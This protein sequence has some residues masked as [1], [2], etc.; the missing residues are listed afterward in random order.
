MK[1]LQTELTKENCICFIRVDHD[2]YVHAVFRV[3]YS[4]AY[5][6]IRNVDVLR[7][8]L[9]ANLVW[10]WPLTLSMLYD[11]PLAW[12]CACMRAGMVDTL[13]ACSEMKVRSRIALKKSFSNKKQMSF[14]REACPLTKSDLQSLGFVINR[15]FMKLF[16]TNVTKAVKSSGVFW[17]F[18]VQCMHGPNAYN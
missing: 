18:S 2:H 15:F 17:F 10:L 5:E 12:P 16:A 14:G 6:T 9:R 13:N 3:L 7:K 11:W 8:R 1:I 4:N